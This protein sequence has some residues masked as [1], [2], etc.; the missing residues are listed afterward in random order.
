MIRAMTAVLGIDV[1]TQSLKVIVCDLDLRV[2]GEH[3][4]GYG[5]DRP[6]ADRAE[7]DPAVWERALAPAI[8]G[9]LAA[10]GCD[11]AV[12]AALAITGQLDGCV[13]VDADGAALGPA[14][15]WQDRR[16]IAEA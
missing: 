4:V 12:V 2:L 10:A 11:P 15:I 16:A 13:A 7:Q 14:L 9:A 3:R 6:A 8:A 5:V 1:G